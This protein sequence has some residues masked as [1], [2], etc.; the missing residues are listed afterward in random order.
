MKKPSLVNRILV[1]LQLDANST[2]ILSYAGRLANALEADLLLLHCTGTRELT[3][4]MQ[5]RAI[6]A[7]RTLGERQLAHAGKAGGDSVKFDCV[8]RPESLAEAI[9][10][11]VQD[12]AAD[13]VL[14]QANSGTTT[15]L[16]EPNQA[17]VVMEA[18]EVPVMVIPKGAAY[19]E[20]KHL[21]FGTDFTDTDPQVLNRIKKFSEQTGA[22]L[23]LVQVYTE[24]D[25]QQLSAMNQAM[26]GVEKL[27]NSS[28]VS[29]TLM[30]EE[31]V[32][33]GISDYAE[34][35]GADM[36]VLATQDSYLP[37]RLL[38]S[39]YLKTM[40]YHT[41]IP[42]LVFRQL[43]RKPCSGCCATCTGKKPE[44]QTA[45]SLKIIA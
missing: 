19:R 21:V 7:L 44:V 40:A 1:P 13:L 45:D 15:D 18:V 8:V 22:R 43:K 11:V 25:T 24:A 41:Q 36:L 42:L 37:Q 2:S 39:A 4:T 3:F 30:E 26:R 6:Q 31:D 9:K 29:C 32:L 34:E 12:Y 35:A 28:R 17:A 10:A 5:S 20:V 23:D 14:M 27:L 38:G 33:E 16:P